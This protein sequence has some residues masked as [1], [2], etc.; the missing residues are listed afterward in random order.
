MS[1][2]KTAGALIALLFFNLIPL[3]V[4]A[5]MSHDERYQAGKKAYETKQYQ[6]TVDILLPLLHIRGFSL[7]KK[8]RA[9]LRIA[10]SYLQLGEWE[11]ARQYYQYLL[12]TKEAEKELRSLARQ[13]LEWLDSYIFGD[14]Q[15][16]PL[17][18]KPEIG[19]TYIFPL[20]LT[21]GG[22]YI[23]P[24]HAPPY[25][26]AVDMPA[27]LG[28]NIYAMTGGTIITLRPSEYGI[29]WEGPKINGDCGKGIIIQQNKPIDYYVY[30]HLQE[31]APEIE[32]GSIVKTG[33]LLGTVGI[34][35][36]TTGPHLHLVILKANDHYK[37][38]W[39]YPI[40]FFLRGV[41]GGA[42]VDSIDTQ[43]YSDPETAWK[44]W[45]KCERKYRRSCGG[46]R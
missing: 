39:P 29:E 8:A 24:T 19:P 37:Y 30:C 32:V 23:S 26:F 10:E 35:G 4:K 33:D 43:C 44:N 41:Q 13:G 15:A 42:D 21:Q 17:V 7:E 40:L 11:K 20:D 38:I 2:L 1:R 31:F 27:P 34:T 45:K 18:E 28:T 25:Q 3:T 22:I 6:K 12:E 16:I 9:I 5:E 14:L 36:R 46:Y